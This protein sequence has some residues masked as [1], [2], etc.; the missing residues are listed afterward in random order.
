[1][2]R[3]VPHQSAQPHY[4]H[5]HIC[6]IPTFPCVKIDYGAAKAQTYSPKAHF[7]QQNQTKL[8]FVKSGRGLD[9]I[10]CEWVEWVDA[11]G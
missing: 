10:G 3:A 11:I 2:V 8:S 5:E 1:M 9:R 4:N 6:R 7:H